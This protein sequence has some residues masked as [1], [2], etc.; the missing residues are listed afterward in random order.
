MKKILSLCIMFHLCINSNSIAQNTQNSNE[1]SPYIET[2]GYAEIEVI[3]NEIYV[4][5]VI[6]EKYYSKKRI[7]V[8]EQETKLKNLLMQTGI[9]LENLYLSD[10]KAN[11]IKVNWQKNAVL[12]KKDY[13]LKVSDAQTLGLIFQGLDSIEIS[14]AQISSIDYSKSDSLKKEIRILAIKNAKE[15]AD[16]LLNAIGEETGKPLIVNEINTIVY[17]RESI[18]KL[19]SRDINSAVSLNSAYYYNNS[20]TSTNNSYEAPKHK[21][22]EFEKIKFTSNIYIKFSIK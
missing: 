4:K 7:S 21:E 14:D 17:K 22:I 5:I 6:H 20:S 3:P 8:E 1:L 12:T 13:T 10:A 18:N 9:D 16:Y 15:K 2:N 11:I 19:P